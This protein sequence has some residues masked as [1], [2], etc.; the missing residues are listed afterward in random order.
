M[1]KALYLISGELLRSLND[2]FSLIVDENEFVPPQAFQVTKPNNAKSNVF[3][4]LMF[5]YDFIQKTHILKLTKFL[6][7]DEDDTCVIDINKFRNITTIELQRIDIQRVRGLQYLR[8]QIREIVAERCINNIKDLLADCGGDKTNSFIWSSLIKVDFSYNNLECVDTSFEFTPYLQHLNLSHNKIFHISALVWLPNLKFLN[9]SYNQLTSVPK[10]NS[11]A[12]RRLQVITINANLLEDVSGIVRLDSLLELDISDN[13]LLDHSN[14]LPLCTLSSLRYLNLS[15]NPLSFHHK[16]RSATCRYL[17]KSAAEVK[18]QLDG[19]FLSKNEKKLAGSYENYYPLFGHRMVTST[20]YSRATPSVKSTCNTPENSSIG[21][22]NSS[23]NL[24]DIH[25]TPSSAQK[26][27]RPRCVEIEESG[28]FIGNKSK[29]KSSKK[30]TREGS[31]EHLTTKKK[32][33]QLREQ[34]GNDWLM[35]H[36][37]QKTGGNCCKE[38]LEEFLDVSSEKDESCPITPVNDNITSMNSSEI[39]EVTYYESV[40]DSLMYRTAIDDSAFLSLKPEDGKILMSD[41]EENEVQFIVVKSSSREDLFLIVSDTSIKEKDAMSMKTITR[42]GIGT[43][44]SVERPKTCTIR[45]TFDTIRK[46]KRERQYEMEAKPCQQLERML[47]DYLSSKPLS[48]MNQTIFK[49]LKCNSEFS[50]ETDDRRRDY[51]MKYKF[52]KNL[53]NILIYSLNSIQESNVLTVKINM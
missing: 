45:F 40:N 52:F 15:G 1:N 32:I 34:F 27:M 16:H 31:K 24:G 6:D 43:L 18:F 48:E 29:T 53:C 13:C 51:G 35:N 38:L 22:V 36:E 10:L 12:P 46:D 33:E 8:S 21:S 19:A 4:E 26:R 39:E 5:I 30:L 9:L 47:R 25:R 11:D 7:N 20:S 2:S 41:P 3:R 17:S 44:E 37:Q 50:R 28:F 23:S 49:C 42:W 14:L